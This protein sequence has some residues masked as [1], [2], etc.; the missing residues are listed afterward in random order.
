[1]ESFKDLLAKQVP[2]LRR[3]AR[4]LTK[5]SVRADDLVQDVF[6]RAMTRE[7]LWEP[8]TSLRSWLFRMTQNVWIDTVRSPKAKEVLIGNVKNIA[9]SHDRADSSIALAEIELALSLLPVEQREVIILFALEGLTYEQT[10]MILAVPVGTVMSRLARGRDLLKRLLDG[11][12]LREPG[13]TK[14]TLR[15]VAA[16]VK[17]ARQQ[18]QHI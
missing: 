2:R 17:A 14:R 16:E 8:G 9:R 10:A 4:S 5:D 11:T 15:S 1:M 12:C 7:H 6:E 13:H 3:F 18:P